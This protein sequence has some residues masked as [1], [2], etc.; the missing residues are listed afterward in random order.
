MRKIVA[1]TDVLAHEN[2]FPKGTT[3]H[4]VDA[5]KADA[6]PP[7]IDARTASV[8]DLNGWCESHAPDKV[9]N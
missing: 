7:E 3:F 9:K 5:P 4:V 1:T 2:R 6:K 8:W